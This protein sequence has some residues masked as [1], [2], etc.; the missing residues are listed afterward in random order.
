MIWWILPIVIM[1]LFGIFM[2]FS[3]FHFALILLVSY[4]ICW[5]IYIRIKSELKNKR[6]IILYTLSIIIS[7]IIFLLIL[8]GSELS[9]F[10]S[11]ILILPIIQ[12]IILSFWVAQ[13]LFL[14]DKSSKST[15]RS[16]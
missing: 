16:E 2:A 13:L 9:N 4:L 3:L 15:P 6:V 5:P 8:N 12:W 7:T 14:A 1:F 10:F 11:R